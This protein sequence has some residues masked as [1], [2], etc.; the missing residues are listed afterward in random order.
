MA[1]TILLLYQ[2]VADTLSSFLPKAVEYGI[3]TAADFDVDSIPER[4][5][6]ERSAAGYAMMTPP[7]V[8]AWCRKPA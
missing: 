4:L 7:L 2:Y 1:A 6:A 8:S 3:A 5:R